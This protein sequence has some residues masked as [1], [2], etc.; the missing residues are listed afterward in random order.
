MRLSSCVL[1]VLTMCKPKLKRPSEYTI[2]DSQW[3]SRTPIDDEPEI[4]H[5]IARFIALF[6]AIETHFPAM[7]STLTGMDRSMSEH[8]LSVTTDFG[9]RLDMVDVAALA[10]DLS[11]DDV[12]FFD[13]VLAE[14]KNLQRRRNLYCHAVMS[15]TDKPGEISMSSFRFD[16]RDTRE[17]IITAETVRKDCV[18]AERLNL[19]LWHVYKGTAHERKP[20]RGKR[21]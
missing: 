18:L 5:E 2:S 7:L 13:E 8:L 14:M 19:A 9:K 12:A 17:E 1:S 20:L 21:P 3:R 16:F 10:A 11:A 4:G 15:R 6:S